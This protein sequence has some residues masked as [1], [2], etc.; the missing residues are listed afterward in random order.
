MEGVLIPHVVSTS[1]ALAKATA[2]PMDGGSQRLV[3]GEQTVGG[4]RDEV[5]RLRQENAE[6]RR[7]K[8]ELRQPAGYW[9]AL[10]T[11]VVEREAKLAKELEAAR[12]EIR[13]LQDKLFGRKSER[14]TGRDR[15]NQ[16]FDPPSR[17]PASL[18]GAAD[19]SLDAGVPAVATTLICR[20]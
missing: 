7:E 2:W 10:H 1:L 11:R 13:K 19:S 15:S 8:A 9:K 12:G 6:L 3:L 4:L 20:P 14:D 18:P 16:L 17:R 5:V